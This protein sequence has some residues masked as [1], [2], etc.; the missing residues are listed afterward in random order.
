LSLGK[1][2]LIDIETTGIDE[3]YDEI[4]D[5]GFLSFEGTKL[6]NTYSSL[7]RSEVELSQFIQKLT[8]I[9]PEQ[10]RKAPTW[11]EVSQEVLQLDEDVLIAHNADFEDKFLTPEFESS[12]NT[13]PRYADTL[14]FLS[15][16]NPG[17]SSLNLESFIQQWQIREN[18][19]HR[20]Y[21]DS[22]DLLKV[23]ILEVLKTYQNPVWRRKLKL[24]FAKFDANEFWFKNFFMLSEEEL[25]NISEQIKFDADKYLA[26]EAVEAASSFQRLDIDSDF[27]SNGIDSLFQNESEIQKILPHYKYRETQG[28]LAA[29][30]GQS[31]KN[32]V[33]A[34]IQA[35]TGTGKTLGYLVPSALF[36]LSTDEKILVSTGTKTLQAQVLDKDIPLLKSLLGDKGEELKVSKLIGSSNHF[37]ELLFRQKEDEE[38]IFQ[39]NFEEQFIKSYFDLIF[40]KNQLTEDNDKRLTRES[41]PF[42]LRKK[43]NNLS[44]WDKELAVNYRA[45]SG[46]K[47]PFSKNCSYIQGL[48]KA[49]ESDI[50]IGNHALTLQWTRSF[51]RPGYIIVDEAHKIENDG[52]Q[53]YELEVNERALE[54]VAKNLSQANGLGSLFYLLA[55]EDQDKATKTIKF[56]KDNATESSK[57]LMGNLQYLEDNIEHFF[58]KTPK[59]TSIYWNEL[60]MINKQSNEALG[61]SIYNR[62]DSIRFILGSLVETLTSYATR[63]STQDF[64]GENDVIAWS[65]FEAFYAGLE[66]LSTALNYALD[67]VD[68]FAHTISYHEREGYKLKSSPIDVGKLIRENLLTPSESV[69][70]TSATLASETGTHGKLGAEWMT[71]Y[72]YLENEKRFKEGLYLPPVYDYVDHAKVY[73]VDDTP[74]LW[75]KDFVPTIMKKLNPFIEDIGGRTLLLF[76]S[77]V[78]F[79]MARELLLKKF[80]GKIPLFIQGMNKNAVEDFKKAENGIL[81]G[82]E[83]FGEG[84]DIPGKKLEFLYIDKIPDMRQDNVIQKR[85]DFFERSFGN[86]FNQY[87]MPYRSRLLHQKLGRL[88]RTETDIGV[89]IVTDSRVKRWKRKTRDD[90]KNLLKPYHIQ[91]V[92]FDEALKKGI[93]FLKKP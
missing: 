11:Q 70:F 72:L 90:F 24:E 17:R 45:C 39:N 66:D 81:L 57:S 37:C 40:F 2:T 35:P 4:I 75:Q 33:H 71:G 79:E 53:A 54:N 62:L 91:E 9:K 63:W 12:L 50:I 80:E 18:E 46:S 64:D 59:Y 86:E 65:R 3:S 10:V 67:N 20:G 43:L 32:S 77:R 73:L 8:G 89:A 26:K 87:F 22:E 88:L 92:S 47:C 49:K 27:S 5:V 93:E 28:K 13:K 7:V 82:M 42:V 61:K 76:S 52:T 58:K 83:S 31:F 1:W 38:A 19:V 16:L 25:L 68:G 60:P 14:F 55:Q 84:I 85:R 69:I 30:V 51:P 34:M 21:E 78:R 6:T 41:L 29:R 23:M 15:I 74:S 56:L 36:S 44:D 48:R